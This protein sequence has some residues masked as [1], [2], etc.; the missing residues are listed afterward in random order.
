M[1]K[2]EANVTKQQNNYPPSSKTR[3]GDSRNSVNVL[4]KSY[5][6]WML[7]EFVMRR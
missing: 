3:F 1:I 7:A 2:V 4:N 6:K 5:K